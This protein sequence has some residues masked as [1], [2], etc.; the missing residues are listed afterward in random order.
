MSGLG[1][2]RKSQPCGGMS[3]LPRGTDLVRLSRH[4]RKVPQREVLASH[5]EYYARLSDHRKTKAL[6][7]PSSRIVL[8]D[9]KHN[10]L[11]R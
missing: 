10:L 5:S 9:F 11:P 2:K 7:E 4:V 6:I 1:Q 3:A 8:E